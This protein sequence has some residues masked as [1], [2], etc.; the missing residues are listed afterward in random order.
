MPE[1]SFE[2]LDDTTIDIIKRGSTASI[3]SVLR[4]Q[5]VENSWINVKSIVPGLTLAGQAVTIRNVP[6]RGDIE[7]LSHDPASRFPRHPEEAIDSVLPGD[8]V[9]QEGSGIS[10]GGIFGDL[11]TMRLEYKKAGGLVTGIPIRDCP[12]LRQ[13]SVPVFCPESSA[14]GSLVFNIDY[15]VPIGCVGVLVFPGDVIVGDDDGV[16]VI[17]LSLADV[18][19]ERILEFEDREDFIREMLRK[20][21]PLQ[22][23]YPPSEEMERT[24]QKW[25]RA[26]KDA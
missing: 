3:T 22:G 7:P 10:R 4:K 16:V 5:G 25:R 15:N 8:I 26:Q 21:N 1:K 6:G 19:A 17:P 12:K 13:Q 24:F 23:L 9:V 20:G 2:R 11:L 14:P 18:V